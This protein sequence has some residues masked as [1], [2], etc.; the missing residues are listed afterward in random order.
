MHNN[1]LDRQGAVLVG[2]FLNNG[3]KGFVI[4]NWID[5]QCSFHPFQKHV[6]EEYIQ[7]LSLKHYTL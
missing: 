1:H 6:V 3:N 7:V 2:D 5:Q 4:S